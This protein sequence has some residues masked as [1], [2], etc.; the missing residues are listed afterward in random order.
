MGQTR[1]STVAGDS[2][3]SLGAR[4]SSVRRATERLVEPLSAEDA[5][6]QS[7]TKCS[8]AKWHLAH[9]SWFFEQMVL[10]T[11]YPERPP[12]AGRASS[13]FNSYYTQL[14]KPF[15][16]SKRGLLTRPSLDE[17]R[18]QRREV[19]DQVAALIASPRGEDAEL[20]AMIEIGLHHEQ[21]HQELIL[22]DIKHLFSE[23]P[24]A[25]AYADPVAGSLVTAAP[26]LG[27]RAFEGGVCEI[28]HDGE[29][30]SYDNEGPRHRVFVEPYELADRLVTNGEWLAF[31]ND[32]GYQRSELWLDAGWRVVEGYGRSAPM[33]W[34][35]CDGGW[36][37]FTLEG[38]R[39]LR[40]A[41]PV[42]HVSFYEA[43][44]YARWAGA[45][46]PT[47]HE[48]ENAVCVERTPVDGM[49]EGSRM[50][51]SAASSRSD[52]LKQMYGSLWQWTRSDYGPYPGY[53]PPDGALGEYN[54]KFMCGQFVLRGASFATPAG[55]SRATY[56]NY[57][58][59]DDRWCFAGVRL[60]REAR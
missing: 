5:I 24:L 44:A 52:A 11:A 53:R 40:A 21:Q 42:A 36:A 4:F 10:K 60:A 13:L 56:R 45:R 47:E 25:P 27:W 30:F 58:H 41:E 48:W 31:M 18:A 46:L 1:V 20:R 16:R 43:D 2:G 50:H 37:E 29:G 35:R 8:P 54:G 34:T 7:M 17:V 39:E 38:L 15:D 26:D 12:P 28:G 22:S 57:Y 9:T 23:S 14:G 6:A 33:Y 32:G 51:P 59:A 3:V 55:H 49:R 19:N